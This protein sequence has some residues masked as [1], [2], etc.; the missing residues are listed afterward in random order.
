MGVLTSPIGFIAA[1]TSRLSSQTRS[2]VG[3]KRAERAGAG[4]D[5]DRVVDTAAAALNNSAKFPTP[6]RVLR[7]FLSPPTPPQPPLAR[8]RSI[9]EA[10]NIRRFFGEDGVEFCAMALTLMLALA[11]V[12][13]VVVLAS[14][15]ALLLASLLLSGSTTVRVFQADFRTFLWDR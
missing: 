12:F 7:L 14:M 2:G 8:R 4:A 6:F 11:R 1:S 3:S 10:G 13:A 9:D 5:P 15:F